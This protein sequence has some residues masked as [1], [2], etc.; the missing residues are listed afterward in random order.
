MGSTPSTDT[1]SNP[2]VNTPS[3][4]PATDTGSSSSGSVTITNKDGL[5]MWWYAVTLSVPSGVTMG[6]LKMKDSTMSA[7]EEGVNEWNYYKFTGNT[8]YSAPFHFKIT[9][10]SGQEFIG[11]NV[12]R[13]ITA[14]DCGQISPTSAYTADNEGRTMTDSIPGYEVVVMVICSVF[15]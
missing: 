4:V 1:G 13:S 7:W 14:G 15:V 2:S 10:S 6:S 5:N 11:Y 8:P 9:T 12:I 3:P